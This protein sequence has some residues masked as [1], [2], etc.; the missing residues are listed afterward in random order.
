MINTFFFDLDGTLL[1]M[2]QDLFIKDYFTRLVRVLKQH[3]VDSETGTKGVLYGT[4]LMMKNEGPHL[5]EDLFWQ[6]FS[7]V[8]SVQKEDV[9][10]LIDHF[11]ATDFQEVIHTTSPIDDIKDVIHTIKDKGYRVVL[12]TNP[13]FP[14]AAT[15]S[16]VK[17]ANLEV[18]LFD[19]VT[20]FENYHASKP[21]L[22]YYQEIMDKMNVTA[23]QVIM[24]GNDVKEDLAIKGL[25]SKTYLVTDNLINRENLEIVSDYTGSMAHFRE[26]IEKIPHVKV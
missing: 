19:E 22:N 15:Y 14:K 4:D 12:A 5:N 20:T 7:Q 21:S 11:Y 13:L 16:R 18:D 17:W 10:E 24:V 9:T 2:D 23:Q 25:G 6:G 1:P 8:T 3:G 26:F